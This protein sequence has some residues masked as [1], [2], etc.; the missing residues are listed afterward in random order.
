MLRLVEQRREDRAEQR[1]R[2][3]R[4]TS[5]RCRSADGKP[6]TKTFICGAT[7]AIS[8]SITFTRNSAT[9][10][11]AAILNTMNSDLAKNRTDVA[12]DDR[13]GVRVRQRHE[14]ERSRDARSAARWCESATRK[15]NVASASSNSPIM[16]MFCYVSGLIDVDDGEADLNVDDLAGELDPGEDEKRHEAENRA[17]RRP[18]RRP[19]WPAR[20]ARAAGSSAPS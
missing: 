12:R 4:I 16:V 9:A 15:S 17:R 8:P 18:A 2:D 6:T 10:T 11:G 20:R 13:L 1:H 3:D 7:R 5:S 19:R 14:V